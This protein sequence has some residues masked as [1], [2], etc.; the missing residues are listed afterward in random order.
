MS[1]DQVPTLRERLEKLPQ[2]LYNEI[3]NWT[4]TANTRNRD[5]DRGRQETFIAPDSGTLLQVDHLSRQQFAASYY[6]GE[7]VVF[8]AHD[9]NA[10]VGSWRRWLQTVPAE[11]RHMIRELRII[12]PCTQSS[13]SDVLDY[14]DRRGKRYRALATLLFGGQVAD[15]LRFGY[16]EE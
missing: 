8:V 9:S 2:E 15:R 12:W 3:Y 10:N 6:G 16:S 11:H 1:S 7:H 5:I 14:Y 13:A 4:F